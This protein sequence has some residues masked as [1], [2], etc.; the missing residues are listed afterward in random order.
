MLALI[1]GQQPLMLQ[2]TNYYEDEMFNGLYDPHPDH[3]RPP[4]L[5]EHQLIQQV[6]SV[7]N[8]LTRERTSD[9]AK[10]D[11]ET[12]RQTD[13]LAQQKKRFWRNLKI[14]GWIALMLSAFVGAVHVIY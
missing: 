14:S 2:R 9:K 4:T 6:K 5:Y 7:S 10:W 1:S 13:E 3:P 11:A 8:L 12:K